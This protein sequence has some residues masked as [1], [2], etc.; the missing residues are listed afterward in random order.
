[1]GRDLVKY[2]DEPTHRCKRAAK[3]VAGTGLAVH[4]T[5]IQHT[6]NNKDLRDRV[7]RK[8]PLLRPQHK[9]ETVWNN[10]LWTEETKMELFGHQVSFEKQTG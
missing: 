6:L 4:G 2:S 8:K 3:R 5:I 1:M 9:P 7:A 10:V